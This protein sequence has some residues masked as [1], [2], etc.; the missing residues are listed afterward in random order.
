[1]GVRG[2]TPCGGENGQREGGR[3][4]VTWTKM[5]QTWRLQAALTVASGACLAGAAGAAATGEDN[6][7]R[8]ADK[9][10]RVTSGP[11]GSGSVREG[12]RGSEAVA[13][14]GTDRRGSSTVPPV[15]F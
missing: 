7:A 9:R 12:V 8:V 2:A 1:V 6:G 4:L 15:Q 13:A 14:S 11:V 3:G 10:D 5:A